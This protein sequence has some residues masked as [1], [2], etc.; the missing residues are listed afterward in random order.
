DRRLR[1]QQRHQRV[2]RRRILRKR[3]GRDTPNDKTQY[4]P[5]GPVP[6][7]E[8]NSRP[9]D[10]GVLMCLD[11]RVCS[12]LKPGAYDSLEVEIWSLEFLFTTS[13]RCAP[14]AWPARP[15]PSAIGGRCPT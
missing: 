3:S 14:S 6:T 7:A 4:S 8:Y 2:A 1:K 10:S 12:L 15:G 13:A 11:C 5:K 9:N